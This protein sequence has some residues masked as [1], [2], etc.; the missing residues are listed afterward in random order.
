MKDQHNSRKQQEN[1][2]N[3]I[4]N[5]AA[6]SGNNNS[7][8]DSRSKQDSSVSYSSAIKNSLHA[9]GGI[10]LPK[11][12]GAIRGIGEKAEVNPVTVSG[13]VS[14]PLPLTPGRL[15][16]TPQLGL[17]YSSGAGNSEFGLGWNVGLPEISRKT[18]KELPLY[19][20]KE[21]SDTF[22]LSGAEDLVPVCDENGAIINTVVGE[23][24][25][26]QYIPRTEGLNARIERITDDSSGIAYWRVTSKDNIVSLYGFS[27]SARIAD[28]KN[29]KHIF[30][31]KLECTVDSLAKLHPIGP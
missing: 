26:R 5:Q 4:Q 17:S 18:D 6:N 29:E 10:E 24:T 13:S 16:F 31:W 15:G 20:D 7:G 25:I 23:N 27:A 19:H 21:N 2:K 11:G 9:P 14:I 30:S 1:N 28:P 12:G 22:I 3:G 8:S